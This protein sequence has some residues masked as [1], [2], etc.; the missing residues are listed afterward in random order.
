MMKFLLLA[1]LALFSQSN[2]PAHAFTGYVSSAYSSTADEAAGAGNAQRW[3]L[4]LMLSEGLITSEEADHSVS[5]VSKFND[6]IF[7][8]YT[9]EYGS[10]R[11]Q[12][13]DFAWSSA[14]VATNEYDSACE[15][16]KRPRPL[17]TK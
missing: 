6:K 1:V 3:L 7:N 9:E 5:I 14:S 8:Q 16:I 2:A 4:C 12:A 11:Y 15:K 13:Y 10:M 17:F